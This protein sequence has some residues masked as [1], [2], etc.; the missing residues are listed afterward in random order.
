MLD[1]I[2]APNLVHFRLD[3]DSLHSNA[4]DMFLR[5]SRCNI[6]SLHLDI[7]SPSRA[8]SIVEF[9]RQMPHVTHL[10]ISASQEIWVPFKERTPDGRFS[11]FPQL[12]HLVINDALEVRVALGYFRVVSEMMRVV[13]KRCGARKMRVEGRTGYRKSE[14]PPIL[15]RL[16]I[17]C[18]L[19]RLQH[20]TLL[21]LSECGA[22]EVYCSVSGPPVE[23]GS[24]DDCDDS[25]GEE[26]DSPSRDGDDDGVAYI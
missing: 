24:D 2:T 3:D 25:D 13:R 20:R 9:S 23:Y 11:V 1:I 4:V 21:A 6:E 12:Q 16:D 8:S 10:A 18:P 14:K 15:R 19:T 7:W 5:R 26:E 17:C 22:L